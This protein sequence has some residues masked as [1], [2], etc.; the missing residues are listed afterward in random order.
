[1]N[2]IVLILLLISVWACDTVNQRERYNNR[3]L[4]RLI[5]QGTKVEPMD[6]KYDVEFDSGRKDN[7]IL[8]ETFNVKLQK[9]DLTGY[10]EDSINIRDKKVY[11]IKGGHFYFDYMSNEFKVKFMAD[12]D[13]YNLFVGEVEFFK[14]QDFFKNPKYPHQIFGTCWGIE[15]SL[16]DHLDYNYNKSEF[17]IKV[18]DGTDSSYSYKRIE[19]KS[20]GKWT[21]IKK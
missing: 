15:D 1:M 11:P 5:G 3:Q 14:R 16:K 4:R 9:W 6:G 7:L 13:G 21:A 20:T 18:Y 12:I 17:W 8:K 19:Y 10:F 2:K